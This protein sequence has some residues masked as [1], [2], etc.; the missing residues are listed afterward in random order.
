MK[1]K[2]AFIV[3]QGN[4]PKKDIE[5][6]KRQFGAYDGVPFEYPPCFLFHDFVTREM[7]V[8]L[9]RSRANLILFAPHFR[10]PPG[11]NPDAMWRLAIDDRH[12][13]HR[14]LAAAWD[15]K[16][17]TPERAQQF[18]NVVTLAQELR[19]LAIRRQCELGFL[20]SHPA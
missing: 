13:N 12:F 8:A 18:G 16:P 15:G 10:A 2:L 1:H 9:I 3:T 19:G 11:K 14:A 6:A 20:R 7:E 4:D 5:E 17:P